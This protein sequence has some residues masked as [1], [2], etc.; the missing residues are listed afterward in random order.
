MSKTINEILSPNLQHHFN[1][2]TPSRTFLEVITDSFIEYLEQ[3]LHDYPAQFF[4]TELEYTTEN[5]LILKIINKI[6]KERNE[7]PN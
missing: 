4:D 7:T 3:E 5:T 6:R 2:E 1:E